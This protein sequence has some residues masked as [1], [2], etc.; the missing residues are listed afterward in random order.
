MYKHELALPRM[1]VDTHHHDCLDPEWNAV[2]GLIIAYNDTLKKYRRGQFNP[3]STINTGVLRYSIGRVRGLSAVLRCRS[4]WHPPPCA[5]DST[6]P[7][8][9]P[10]ASHSFDG[11]L[12]DS[13]LPPETF[14][15]Y[16]SLF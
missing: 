2:L 15:S 3:Y 16:Y 8:T 14:G 1:L 12:N 4:L 5:S 11:A 6:A 13:H 7:I 9:Q 10:L